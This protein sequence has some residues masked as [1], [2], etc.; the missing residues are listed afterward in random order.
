[1]ARFIFA[2][3]AQ[4]KLQHGGN[5]L[6]NLQASRFSTGCGYLATR[7]ISTTGNYIE[8]NIAVN[9]VVHVIS[10]DDVRTMDRPF[11]VFCSHAIYMYVCVHELHQVIVLLTVDFTRSPARLQG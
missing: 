4:V 10:R 7:N 1:M 5:V 8:Y 2:T 9:S 6:S 3:C 11:C